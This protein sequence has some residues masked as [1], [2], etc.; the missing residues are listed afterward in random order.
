MSNVRLPYSFL[1]S[2]GTVC[3]SCCH[4]CGLSGDTPCTPICAPN[5]GA[6]GF[7][8]QFLDLFYFGRSGFRHGANALSIDLSML[9]IKQYASAAKD[10]WRKQGSQLYCRWNQLLSA[11]FAASAYCAMSTHSQFLANFYFAISI[12]QL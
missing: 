2:I 9:E 6:G 12:Y 7:L 10:E 3:C 5:S 11:S 4:C 8:D 1:I